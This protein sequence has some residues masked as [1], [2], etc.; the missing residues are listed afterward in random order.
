MRWL[1]NTTINFELLLIALLFIPSFVL[2]QD[3]NTVPQTVKNVDLQK[4]TGTWYEIAKVPNSFQDH[5]IKSTTATYQLDEDGEIIVINR[6][7]DEDGEF[8]EAEGV[9]R[10][11][12]T[13]SNSKLEV[14][15]VSLLGVNLF[16][17]DYW[18]IGLEENY[19]YVVVGTPSRKYG[20]ILCRTPKMEEVDLEECFKIMED[21]GYRR[22][23]FVMSLQE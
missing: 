4:Y 6:C 1:E 20:W 9:A 18:I 3:E 13:I 10:V 22:N 16:W 8:D 11:I 5:C 12:D 23:D 21:N 17:G 7:K 14:S 2:A 19:K 15:F